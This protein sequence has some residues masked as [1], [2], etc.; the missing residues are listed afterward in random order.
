VTLLFAHAEPRAAV[1]LTD[2]LA[3][4]QRDGQVQPVRFVAKCI[5]IPHLGLAVA[6]VGLG[7]AFTAVAADILAGRHPAQDVDELHQWMPAANREAWAHYR[8][9]V[10]RYLVDAQ[11]PAIAGGHQLFTFGR[12]LSEGRVRAYMYDSTDDFAGAELTGNEARTV[13]ITH[14]KPAGVDADFELPVDDGT[15][16]IGEWIALADKLHEQEA[17]DCVDDGYGAHI[18]GELVFTIVDAGGRI[19]HLPAGRFS[20]YDEQR[21]AMARYWSEHNA[22]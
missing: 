1:I 20:N 3:A 19:N 10:D 13:S 2:T 18:G 16:W 9:L 8:P 4:L 14:P 11:L 15:E 6:A 22:G 21:A 5:T 17:R 12:S 7:Q